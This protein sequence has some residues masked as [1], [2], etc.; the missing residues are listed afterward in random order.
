MLSNLQLLGLATMLLSNELLFNQTS[1]HSNL[2]LNIDAR[3]GLIDWR[4]FRQQYFP[5]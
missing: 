5:K 2:I 1:R 4:G 3:L